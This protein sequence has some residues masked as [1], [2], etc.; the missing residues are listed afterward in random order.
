MNIELHNKVKHDSAEAFNGLCIAVCKLKYLQTQTSEEDRK[1]RKNLMAATEEGKQKGEKTAT[2]IK[3]RGME[4]DP[5]PS[6]QKLI[7]S[8]QSNQCRR[9]K[10]S[11]KAIIQGF[12]KILQNG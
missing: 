12:E 6:R 2:K 11:L 8:I 10:H 3:H 7:I 1:G 5:P 4:A 9:K